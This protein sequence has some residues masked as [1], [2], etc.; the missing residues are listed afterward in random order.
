MA[1]A[2]GTTPCG[3][4]WWSKDQTY[5]NAIA[6]ELFLDVAAHLANRVTDHKDYYLRWAKRE[7]RWCMLCVSPT[8]SNF[9][10]LTLSTVQNSGMINA[11]NT[12]N[13]GLDLETCENNGGTVWY[14]INCGTHWTGA[15]AFS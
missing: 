2:Y 14:G 9:V 13:D 5:V 8:W 12:I 11:E 7:W 6:N 10:S 1:K 4:L 3:G 15:D